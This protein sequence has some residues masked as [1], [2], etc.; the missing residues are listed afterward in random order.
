MTSDASRIRTYTYQLADK[1]MRELPDEVIVQNSP[2]HYGP[3]LTDDH[4]LFMWNALV[5]HYADQGDV[6]LVRLYQRHVVEGEPIVKATM[7]EPL[8]PEL[9][10]VVD[11]I[12]DLL[13]ADRSKY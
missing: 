2:A 8:E 12:V 6:Q 4:R 9:Q 3:T 1:H 13:W 5:D 11:Q 7:F 10:E